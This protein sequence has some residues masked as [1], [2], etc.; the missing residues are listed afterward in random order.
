MEVTLDARWLIAFLL[1]FVRAAAWLVVVPPFSNR[2][3]IPPTAMAGVAAGL[4]VLATPHL[5]TTALPTDTAGLVG[6]VV[7]QALTGVA[8]GFSVSILLQALTAAG[9]VIDIFGGINPPPS[10]DPLSENQT[11][12]L[13]QFYEQLG[14][15]LLFASNGEFLII[16]GFESTFA[17][18]GLTLASTKQI[19]SVLVTD[20]V[21]FFTAALEIA[22]PIVVVLFAAQIGMAMLAK[23]APQM[24]V[25]LLSFPL[26]VLLSLGLVA[27]ALQTMP[28]VVD[29]LVERVLQSMGALLGGH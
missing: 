4:A 24:N 9:G 26:Q 21:T 6:A 12:I 25:W 5:V 2:K 27:V 10:L 20:L 28:G 1:A 29:H 8:L 22:A 11:P 16:K 14:L 3:I 19:S 13:G 17:A 18:S 7:L 23:A 15:A